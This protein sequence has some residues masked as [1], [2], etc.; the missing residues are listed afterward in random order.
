MRW[1]QLELLDL[2]LSPIE[3]VKLNPNANDPVFWPELINEIPLLI[4]LCKESTQEYEA[5][6]RIVEW[7][8]VDLRSV[9]N[10]DL[11]LISV[12]VIHLERLRVLCCIR[13]WWTS[14]LI[15]KDQVLIE[16]FF[17]FLMPTEEADLVQNNTDWADLVWDNPTNPC[18]SWRPTTRLMN[19][20]SL[21]NLLAWR[22]HLRL[23]LA[24]W[25]LFLLSFLKVWCPVI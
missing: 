19:L 5:L 6:R 8:N 4:M 13:D 25:I 15:M 17:I 7:V 1:M 2:R 3:Y 23:M 11:Y 16:S 14:T 12:L 9:M 21:P 10:L 20:I 22:I 18:L 24:L